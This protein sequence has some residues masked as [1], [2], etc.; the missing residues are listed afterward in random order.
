MCIRDSPSATGHNL[1]GQ[2]RT[3]VGGRDQAD[4]LG[5]EDAAVGPRL[6]LSLSLRPPNLEQE[7]RNV[8]LGTWAQG[9]HAA[10]DV[11]GA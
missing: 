6:S 5:A 11:L 3:E 9:P 1:L 4:T 10:Q 2:Q 8:A 7:K